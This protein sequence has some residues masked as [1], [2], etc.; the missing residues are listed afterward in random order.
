MDY[1]LT[2]LPLS[3]Y[4]MDPP[5][6]AVYDMSSQLHGLLPPTQ[7]GMIS[8]YRALK[9]RPRTGKVATRFD[10]PV[11][12]TTSPGKI[13]RDICDLWT[14]LANRPGRDFQLS[15]I[16]NRSLHLLQRPSFDPAYLLVLSRS[17]EM[18]QRAHCLLSIRWEGRK[19]T[20][21]TILPAFCNWYTLREL[22]R[23]IVSPLTGVTME[24]SVNGD[25]LDETM[26]QVLDGSVVSVYLFEGFSETIQNEDRQVNLFHLPPNTTGDTDVCLKAFVPQGQTSARISF[27]MPYRVYAL[28]E[29]SNGHRAELSPGVAYHGIS[30]LPSARLLRKL[31]SPFRSYC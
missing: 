21:A 2:E 27:C 19:W 4:S 9:Q 29:H 25:L 14:D 24:A 16:L 8:V 17:L 1:T 10:I 13:L 18:R 31:S 12:P 6:T 23:R 11:T 26:V 22:F 20:T 7:Q 30:P 3:T 28:A 15:P 5:Q